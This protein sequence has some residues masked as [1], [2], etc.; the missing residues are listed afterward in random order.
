MGTRTTDDT[1]LYKPTVAES[2]YDTPVNTNFDRIGRVATQVKAFY[3][4]PPIMLGS[5][6]LSIVTLGQIA[7]GAK[8]SLG[9]SALY[10][11]TSVNGSYDGG[12]EPE[13]SSYISTIDFSY[14]FLD[15]DMDK[16]GGGSPLSASQ[17]S[18]LFQIWEQD[19]QTAEWVVVATAW[20][21]IMNAM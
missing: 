6:Q 19:P 16:I 5:T 8:W 18:V 20:T 15:I 11:F 10:D 21:I 4:V 2:G 12:S 17:L 7:A 14:E 9:S 3:P 1:K 13:R